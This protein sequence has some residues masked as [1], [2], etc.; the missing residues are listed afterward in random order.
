MVVI[1]GNALNSTL[2]IAIIVPLTSKLKGYPTSVRL[3]PG[4]KNGLKTEADALPFQIRTLAMSRF[5]KLIGS[6]TASDM[7]AI[8]QGLFAVLVH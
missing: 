8:L 1:S 3:H 2:P 7:R 5:K 6:V 4:K